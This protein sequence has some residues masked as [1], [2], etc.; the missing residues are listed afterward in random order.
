MAEQALASEAGKIL[1]SKRKQ[2]SG[3]C[4][5]CGTSYTGLT[6]KRYCSVKC[7]N[8]ESQRMHR[9]RLKGTVYSPAFL[10]NNHGLKG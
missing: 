2:G 8:R 4:D 9:A 5:S 6:K 1:A 7:L 10:A 3:T